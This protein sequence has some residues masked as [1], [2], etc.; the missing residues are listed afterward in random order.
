MNEA[1][2]RIAWSTNGASASASGRVE[3]APAGSDPTMSTPIDCCITA[4]AILAFVLAARWPHPV[5]LA[6][7]ILLTL[8]TGILL[9]ANLRPT[10]W[11]EEL[12]GV[13]S[14]VE[15]DPI[16]KAMFWRG[17]PLSP[18]MICLIH[19]MRFHPSGI[20]GCVLV[21]DGA[22]FVAV[23]FAT[24]VLCERCLRWLRYRNL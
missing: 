22:L 4:V 12:G 14:P 5:H 11:Q 6:T 13:D 3:M 18:F 24:K 17:W 16:T 15:L 23:L 7:T 1:T 20:E 19:G 10:G 2:W 8:L 9:W 21:F